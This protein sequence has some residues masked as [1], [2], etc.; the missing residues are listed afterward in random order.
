MI[1]RFQLI[2]VGFIFFGLLV[3]GAGIYLL[4]KENLDQP[5]VSVSVAATPNPTIAPVSNKPK[6]EPTRSPQPTVEPTATPV[7]RPP[8]SV[9]WIEWNSGFRGNVWKVSLTSETWFDTGIP[10]V[11]NDTLNISEWG[12]QDTDTHTLERGFT[13]L[14]FDD[15]L[16]PVLVD[17]T[18]D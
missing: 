17:R 8:S 9:Q 6:T 14:G 4:A 11:T 12:T 10:Y 3:F 15:R 18:S 5:P 7:K 2:A 1:K 13:L 16:L